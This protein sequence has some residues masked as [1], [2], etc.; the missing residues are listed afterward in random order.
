MTSFQAIRKDWDPFPWSRFGFVRWTVYKCPLCRKIFKIAWGPE[1]VL[2]GPGQRV[3]NGCGAVFEDGSREWPNLTRGEK[4]QY[5]FP[6]SVIGVFGGLLVV[7]IVTLLFP[8]V[9]PDAGG[10]VNWKV[11]AAFAIFAVVLFGFWFLSRCLE[12]SRSR[13]RHRQFEVN[14]NV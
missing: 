14:A 13:G 3:C 10:S 8:F 12:I 11:A 6:V 5:L 1:S 4:Q 7:C 2:L 9:L